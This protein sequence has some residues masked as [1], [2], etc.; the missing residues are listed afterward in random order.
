MRAGAVDLVIETGTDFYQ[1]FALY[2]PDV[3]VKSQ[4]V[5]VGDRFYLD[6]VPELV[7]SVVHNGGGTSFTFRQGLWWQPK[8]WLPDDETVMSAVAA[9]ILGARASW[10]SLEARHKLPTYT[11]DSGAQLWVYQSADVTDLYSAYTGT[12]PWDLYVSTVST[13]WVRLAEGSLT[14]VRGESRNEIPWG[15]ASLVGV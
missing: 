1:G 15:G 7:H 6:R 14:V 9:P 10:T 4:E 13:G 2:Q 11:Q 3:P 5:S 8:L 12:W